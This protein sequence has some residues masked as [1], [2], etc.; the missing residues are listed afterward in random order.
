MLAELLALIASCA[1]ATASFW[2]IER[3]IVRFSAHFRSPS[4]SL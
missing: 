2:I 4:Q 3:P 1:A